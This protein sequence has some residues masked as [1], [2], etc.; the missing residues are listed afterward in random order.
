MYRGS[1]ANSKDRDACCVLQLRENLNMVRSEV[2]IETLR[3]A[4][5]SSQLI[6]HWKHHSP[7]IRETATGTM[8]TFGSTKYIIEPKADAL[9]ISIEAFDP[10]SLDKAKLAIE[11]HIDRFGFRELP[12]AWNWLQS[13]SSLS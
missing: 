9:S 6:S 4:R 5:Y 1:K 8:M 10:V 2:S 13:T 7:I 3:A 12:F 11:E